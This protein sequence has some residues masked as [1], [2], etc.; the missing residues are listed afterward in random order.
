M[1]VVVAAGGL[2]ELTEA[3]VTRLR[4]A[5]YRQMVGGFIRGEVSQN[6]LELYGAV[7]G[8]KPGWVWHRVQERR[9]AIG[10]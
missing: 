2:A 1:H 6:E 7:K 3:E 5:N 9:T 8:Y 4:R 10:R